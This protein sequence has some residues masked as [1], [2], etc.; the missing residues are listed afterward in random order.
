MRALLKKKKKA[1]KKSADASSDDVELSEA[2]SAEAEPDEA[3]TDEAEPGPARPKAS[4]KTRFGAWW[5]GVDLAAVETGADEADPGDGAGSAEA[6]EDAPSADMDEEKGAADA[7]GE[8]Q[9]ADPDEGT[10]SAPGPENG[11]AALASSVPEEVL[12]GDPH[13]PRARIQV[14][15]QVWG[16]GFISPGGPEYILSTVESLALNDSKRIADLGAGLGGPAR[17]LAEK[18]GVSVTGYEGSPSLAALGMEMSTQGGVAGIAPILNRDPHSV[19]LGTDEFD[20]IFSKEIFFALDQKEL[21][22]E[23]TAMAIKEQGALLITDYVL[24]QRGLSSPD[25]KAWV[26]SEPATPHLWCSDDYKTWCGENSLEIEDIENITETHNS[27]ILDAWRKF[28]AGLN[29][30]PPDPSVA[31]AVMHEAALWS[32][33]SNVLDSGDVRVI[34]L[35]ARKLAPYVPL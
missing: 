21:L 26:A 31:R 25:V 12:N 4:L 35:R 22:L 14:A 20:C 7:G 23:K 13:W 18:L 19:D 1:K 2:Q 15:E 11:A 9:A 30:N 29:E 17:V 5:D 3:E 34:R 6:G 10:S 24:R 8:T 33:R 16:A 28:N 27:L 32:R